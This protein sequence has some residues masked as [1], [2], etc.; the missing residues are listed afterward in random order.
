MDAAGPLVRLRSQEP[1]RFASLRWRKL[2]RAAVRAATAV[3]GRLEGPASDVDLDA[4][5]EA[6]AQT[7]ETRFLAAAIDHTLGGAEHRAPTLD[8]YRIGY[9]VRAAALDP[10]VAGETVEAL[11]EEALFLAAGDR[12]PGIDGACARLALPGY[13]GGLVPGDP[14]SARAEVEAAVTSVLS[15]DGA[16][17][18]GSPGEHIAVLGRLA[19]L[20]DSGLT[21]DPVLV[22]LRRGMEEA[23]AWMVAPDG[24]VAPVGDTTDRAIG[25]LWAGHGTRPGLMRTAYRHPALLHAATA[26]TDGVAPFERLRVFP[27]AGIAVVKRGWP[28][29]VHE[30]SGSGYLLVQGLSV[31]RSQSDDLNL[32]WFDRGR[33]ILSEA[34]GAPDLV[35]PIRPDQRWAPGRVEELDGDA[36]LASTDLA[37]YARSARAHNTVEIDGGEFPV[38]GGE[39][40][41]RWGEIRETVVM[42]AAACHGRFTHRRSIA[43]R[44]GEW[45]LVVDVIA[46]AEGRSGLR[47]R[48]TGSLHRAR[49]SVR[50]HA[51]RRLDLVRGSGR[52][53]LA[54]D[55]QP[56][57]WATQLEPGW[58]PLEAER[59]RTEEPPQG[60]CVGPGGRAVPAW[61]FG[62]EGRVPGRSAVL[63]TIAGTDHAGRAGRDAYR[64]S[65]GGSEV[66]VDMRPEG[67]GDVVVVGREPS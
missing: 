30:L 4:L 28:D 32:V 61:S 51:G 11:L 65:S 44:P 66:R 34:G 55:G 43:Y 52:L 14:E 58:R 20:I 62:W 2:G 63:F 38:T 64:W 26:G 21:D 60:W 8:A 7:G 6:H 56:V 49:A 25:G 67:I 18:S 10:D 54:A 35:Q 40:L 24:S 36:P 59:A 22:S 29:A 19:S 12:D 48:V 16:H 46:G 31:E 1:P 47:T 42:D 15:S 13:L 23:L 57:A 9:L 53:V 37:A 17:R 33:W 45:L 3:V 5:A 50:F 27:R 39:G 41:V